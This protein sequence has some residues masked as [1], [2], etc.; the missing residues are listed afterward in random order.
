MMEWNS[1]WER[2]HDSFREEEAGDQYLPTISL[3]HVPHPKIPNLYQRCFEYLEPWQWS[4]VTELVE[5][6]QWFFA[7]SPESQLRNGGM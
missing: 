7:A 2:H 4:P 5:T 3:I 1:E 6:G